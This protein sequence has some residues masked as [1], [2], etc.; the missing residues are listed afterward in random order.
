MKLRVEKSQEEHAKVK[1]SKNRLMLNEKEKEICRSLYEG[2][3]Q[4]LQ[5]ETTR[6]QKLKEQ[7][8]IYFS[9]TKR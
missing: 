1:E 7:M 9:L 2:L 6:T 5:D 8:V 3:D 4:Y